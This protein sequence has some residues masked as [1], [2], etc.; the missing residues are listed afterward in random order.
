MARPEPDA[1]FPLLSV[2]LRHLEGELGGLVP[3]T[4]RWPPS[5][6]STCCTRWEPRPLPLEGPV[7]AQVQAVTTAMAPWRAECTYMNF[8]ETRREPGA[9]WEPGYDRLKAIKAAV[10]PTA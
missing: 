6:E 2:E 4:E 9:F 3:G 5:P 1:A 10:T 7:G 8:A